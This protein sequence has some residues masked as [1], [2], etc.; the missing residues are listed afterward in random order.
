[1][2]K[3]E[4]LKLLIERRLVPA[5]ALTKPQKPQKI[6]NPKDEFLKRKYLLPALKQIMK[7]NKIKGIMTMKKT[8]ILK[9]LVER[10]LLPTAI[11]QNPKYA[12]LK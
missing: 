4:I 9:L 11:P 5:E 10:R 2:K 6:V 1:M 8:E 12:H 3:P 7:D